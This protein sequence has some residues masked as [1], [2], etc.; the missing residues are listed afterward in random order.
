MFYKTLLLLLS[1][2]FISCSNS[3][4]VSSGD[5]EE[6][7]FVPEGMLKVLA[8]DSVAL[9]GTNDSS[10]KSNERPQMKV[11]FE[12]NFAMSRGEVTCGMF[13]SLMQ[14]ATGLSLDCEDDSL[15]A[16]NV[17]YYDAVLYANERS[18]AEGFDTA[19]TYGKASFDS[20]HHCTNLEGISYHAD[21]KA[22]RLPTEAEWVLVASRFADVEK[23]WTSDNSGYR[24]HPVCTKAGEDEFC[25]LFGNALEWVNDWFGNFGDTTLSNYVGAPDGGA[26]GQ[27]VVKGGSYRNEARSISLHSRG[28]VYTVVSSTRAEYVGFRL[29]FGAIPGAT[30]MGNDGRATTNHVVSLANISTLRSLTGSYKIK[31]AF[32]NDVSGNLAFIDYSSGTLSVSEIVDTISAYHP[33]I[34]PDGSKVAFCTGLEGVSGKSSLYVRDLNADGTNL[35]KL[36]VESAAIPRWRVL[37]KG[38]TVIVYVTGAGNNK[39]ESN[40]RKESTWQVKFAGGKFG[41]PEKLFDGAYHGGI[42]EDNTLA[43]TGARL[44]RARVADSGST[45]MTGARDTV[46]YGREQA[47]N[48]SLAKDSSKRTLFLDFGKGPGREFVEIAYGT[49]E[50]LFVADS[51][52]TLIQSVAAPEGYSF[53]HTEWIF[54]KENLVVA[55]LANSDGAHAKIALVNL[56]DGSIVELAE[57]DELWHPSFW[58]NDKVSSRKN[59]M[60]SMDSAGVYYDENVWYNALEL[61]VKMENFWYR[62]GEV[63]VVG[64][65]S[66]RMMF[67]MYEK[68]VKSEN[69]LNMAYSAGDMRGMHYLLKNYLLLH[70]PNLK[71]IV[72]EMSPDLLWY[73]RST[74]WGPIIDG[75]PGFKYDEDHGFWKDGLPEGFLSNVA[76]CPKPQTALQHPY[77]LE[78]FLLPNLGWGGSD[79]FRD[80]A[81]MSTLDVNYKYNF[82]LFE[83]IVELA[84]ERNLKVICFIA[85]QSPDYRETGSF[86]VYGPK[87]SV[88]DS[89]LSVVKAM[90][91]VWMDENMM[92]DHDYTDDMAYNVDHLSAAG[93]TQLTLRLD[94]LLETLK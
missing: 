70:I 44:L 7:V 30:W 62:R 65:G 48:A 47:C 54:G 33:D 92:G 11:R 4:G 3:V 67:G 60:L 43:V 90:D 74:S 18:K 64:L 25:D 55:A 76:D 24:L 58:V 37:E 84:K 1:L 78:D 83:E 81:S 86:G 19:Y 21:A 59:P 31:L 49:H 85:P 2:L 27:R 38:D 87:R 35:V 72:I 66:S 77:N 9:L 69:F 73:D 75:V 36:D 32:R 61:R 12:Y 56:T 52:G 45:V 63:T 53:D 17:T 51:T 34:S 15:P 40:F 42:S 80:T 20:E 28:D 46:W 93:A 22:Y 14:V 26:L 39:N 41:K 10:A 71:A 5:S 13:D 6:D 82:Q 16:T 68:L 89:I 50:R 23:G 8:S 79:V 57:G 91:V 94:S 88:A 29:A